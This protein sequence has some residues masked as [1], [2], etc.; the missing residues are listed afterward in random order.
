MVGLIGC[1]CCQDPCPPA[2]GGWSWESLPLESKTTRKLTEDWNRLSSLNGN[3]VFSNTQTINGKL[4]QFGTAALHYPTADPPNSSIADDVFSRAE[5]RW[6]QYV[7]AV[8]YPSFQINAKSAY[9]R[10]CTGPVINYQPPVSQNPGGYCFRVEFERF[11][12]FGGY[13]LKKYTFTAI[14]QGSPLSPIT[15]GADVPPGTVFTVGSQQVFSVEFGSS[16]AFTGNYEAFGNWDTTNKVWDVELK[17][18][19]V[20]KIKA[21][22]VIPDD[23]LNDKQCYGLFQVEGKHYADATPS[24]PFQPLPTHDNTYIKYT[25]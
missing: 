12:L 17:E 5:F 4:Q 14:S 11:N 24:S 1:G 23:H 10:V 16:P 18:N 13:G 20:V 25:Y 7:P 9:S 19:G 22:G 8:F 21:N 3:W 15:T 6:E 2:P